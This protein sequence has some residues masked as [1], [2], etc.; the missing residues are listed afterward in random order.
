MQPISIQRSIRQLNDKKAEHLKGCKIIFFFSCFLFHSSAPSVILHMRRNWTETGFYS[1]RSITSVHASI[2]S[3]DNMSVSISS[4][5]LCLS[6]PSL[7]ALPLLFFPP[8]FFATL[9]PGG[10]WQEA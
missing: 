9:S 10:L 2:T 6:R 5:P 7:S 8:T 1:L 3:H 4:V